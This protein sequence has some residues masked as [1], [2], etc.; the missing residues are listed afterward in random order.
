MTQ[1]DLE[2]LQ[3]DVKTAFL[4][5]DLEEEVLMDLPEGINE[6]FEKNA[7]VCRL[8]KSLYGLKQAARCW[9]EKF[10]SVIKA[11]NLEQCEADK[12]IFRGVVSD[13]EVIV[14]LF[15]DDGLIA[16][17]SREA[18]KIILNAISESFEI[19]VGDSCTFVGVQ[20]MRNRERRTMFI[21][22]KSYANQIIKKFGCENVKP[23][24]IPADPNAILTP[25]DSD[26]IAIEN[27]PFREAVGSLM[28]L[29]IVS[30]PDLAY[31]LNNVS[32]FLNKHNESHWQA[33]KRII[34]Y[35]SGTLDYGIL[36]E[37][38]ENDMNLVGFSDSDFAG[39]PETRRSTSGFAFCLASGVV[40][41]ASQRQRLV[42]LSTT[43]AEYVAA[44]TAAKEAVWLRKLLKDL[45]RMGDD[46]IV[47]FLD[48]Q[49]AIRLV[50]N[51]EFHK[52]TKH[53]DIKYHFIREKV[54]QGDLTF[55]YVCSN[56]QR[57]DIFT[58]PF[59]KQRFSFLRQ[60]LGVISRA[61]YSSGEAVGK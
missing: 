42:T 41:W 36:Y 61:E 3:F 26:E 51:P 37:K 23:V 57:A 4:Y 5:G 39:D 19:K 21:H 43:E 17:S 60:S 31:A 10:K 59:A 38:N 47:L 56:E 29:A 48:N 52:R 53:I 34:K 32:K 11:L 58:K 16:S 18:S 12:C 20:I 2:L 14:A 24:S 44:A 15:V 22:Q 30:R 25:V 9:N 45:G 33:V 6:N 27:V 8:R 1:L 50:K 49:S 40:T 7:F 28:F 35:L 13:H 46:P 55:K 54:D